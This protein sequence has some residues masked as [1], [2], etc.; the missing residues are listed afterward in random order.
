MKNRYCLRIWK[1]RRNSCFW[2]KKMMNCCFGLKSSRCSWS[3]SSHCFCNLKMMSC[4]F[5][6]KKSLNFLRIFCKT[7][8]RNFWLK[9]NLSCELLMNRNY[10]LQMIRSCV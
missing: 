9:K 4:C 1:I 7:S 8:C 2:M 3:K 6:W 5:L 10:V